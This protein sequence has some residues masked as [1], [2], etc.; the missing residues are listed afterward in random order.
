MHARAP[1]LPGKKRNAQRSRLRRGSQIEVHQVWQVSGPCA[2]C[3]LSLRPRRI[4][5]GYAM[6]TADRAAGD[7]RIENRRPAPALVGILLPQ[8]STRQVVVQADLVG[9]PAVYE[10]AGL[11]A[12][13]FVP[14][15]VFDLPD[16]DVLQGASPE[17][18]RPR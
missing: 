13:V 5:L 16:K 4:A 1:V 9:Q 12:K 14:G 18:V 11:A 2:I 3:G 17:I 6:Q 15:P 8:L 10:G 7:Q